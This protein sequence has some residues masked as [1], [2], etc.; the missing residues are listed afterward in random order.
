M[1]QII[2]APSRYIQ[3]QG[4]IAKLGVHVANLGV[5]NGYAIVDP[6]IYAHYKEEIEQSFIEVAM[7]VQLQVFRGE[8]SQSQV[9][10]ILRDME[11]TDIGVILGIGGGK[12]MDTAKA[13]SHFASLPVVIVPT[14]ASTDAPC[15]ALSVLYTDEGRLDR[16][17]PL[18]RNPDLVIADVGIIAKAPPRLLAAGMGDAL[19]TFYEARAC[20]QSGAVTLAGGDSS[21][22]ALALAR[23]CRD[24]LLADGADALHAAREG[25]ITPALEH[26]IEA[27][28]Y[29]SGIGF[30]SGGLAAAHAIHNGLTFLEEC[31]QMVHGEKVA[32]GTI[33]Q[34]VL[35][36][37]PVDEIRQMIHFCR[38]VGLPVTLEELGI[39]N[40]E[41]EKLFI[42][43][44]ASCTEDGPMRNMPIKVC[45]DD[46]LEAIQAADRFGQMA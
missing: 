38:E 14:V 24:T 7:A 39:N 46:V 6:F 43:A 30:E 36:Q 33:V 11:G 40:P 44:K 17:L 32:F 4:E 37:A 19:S 9:E 13:V 45:I 22:A 31:R 42:V 15:S 2:T 20:H 34:L 28:I 8:C 35:E 21:I 27:N 12:T 25:K 29:L 41:H 1:T 5:R 18:T 3:G 16:Y 26:I 23:A 10:A